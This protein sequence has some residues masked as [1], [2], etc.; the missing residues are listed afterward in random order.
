MN[1]KNVVLDMEC[2]SVDM[3]V[4]GNVQLFLDGAFVILS[5]CC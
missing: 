3:M 5:F 1:F 4:N 2:L